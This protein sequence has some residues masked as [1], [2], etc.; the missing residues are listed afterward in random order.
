MSTWVKAL[1]FKG[2]EFNHKILH[3]CQVRSSQKN[4]ILPNEM[5]VESI[6]LKVKGPN[7]DM[8]GDLPF[9]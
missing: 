2:W 9:D 8:F 7:H 4:G 5:Y 1:F 6:T 3:V